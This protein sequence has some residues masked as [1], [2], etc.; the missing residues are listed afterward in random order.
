[1]N[2][3]PAMHLAAAVV[4]GLYGLISLVGGIIGYMK[5]NSVA[6]LV[7][8][9]IC[10][11]LLILCAVGI[12]RLPTWSLGGAMVIALALVGRFGGTLMKSQDSFSDLMSKG[13]GITAMTMIVGGILV[14][15]VCGLALAQGPRT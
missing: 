9:G 13:S 1:V 3:L 6:S 5:A 7:A 11:I 2:N 12:P 4:T 8:G 10:G 14:L 15:A